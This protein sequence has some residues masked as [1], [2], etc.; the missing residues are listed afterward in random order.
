MMYTCTGFDAKLTFMIPERLEICPGLV[1]D[2]AG[3]GV[4]STATT[5]VVR[6]TILQLESRYTTFQCSRTPTQDS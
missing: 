4:T 1:S 6:L 5:P 3:T 2:L